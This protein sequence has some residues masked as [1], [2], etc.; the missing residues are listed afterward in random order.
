MGQKGAKGAVVQGT[1]PGQVQE[2]KRGKGMR[3]GGGDADGINLLCEKQQAGR[4]EGVWWCRTSVTR[5]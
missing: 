2:E 3:E 1:R 5:A 4:I